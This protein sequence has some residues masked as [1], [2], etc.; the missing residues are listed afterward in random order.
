[1]LD[2][3]NVEPQLHAKLFLARDKHGGAHLLIVHLRTVSTEDK[4]WF[5]YKIVK[6]REA[7]LTFATNAS[8]I[9]AI[10]V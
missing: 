3:T 1:M 6:S 5:P 10:I 4:S 9:K 7:V 8:I 2:T